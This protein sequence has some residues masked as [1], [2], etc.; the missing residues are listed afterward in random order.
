MSGISL[1][2][3]SD[4]SKEWQGRA[5]IDRTYILT[6]DDWP[7]CGYIELPMPPLDSITSIVYTDS[8]GTNNTWSSAEYQVDASGF[9]GRVSPA[10][11]YSWPSSVLRVMAGVTVTYK[12]GYGAATSDV[13]ERIK[14]AI[15]MVLGDLWENREDSDIV[16]KYKVPW[17]V[18]GLLGFDRVNPI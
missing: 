16:Q 6:L 3:L 18:K 14:H 1:L 9:V 8:S 13:P 15:K 7:E 5:Y 10:Y 17:G 12:A 11:G 2:D 4:I